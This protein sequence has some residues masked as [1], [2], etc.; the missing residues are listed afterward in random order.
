MNHNIY[1]GPAPGPVGSACI[2]YCEPD[3]PLL[4]VPTSTCPSHHPPSPGQLPQPLDWLSWSLLDRLWSIFP[5]QSLRNLQNY[6][7][8]HDTHLHIFPFPSSSFLSFLSGIEKLDEQHPIVIFSFSSF[9]E[10]GTK[11]SGAP[12]LHVFSSDVLLP[13]KF[14]TEKL[15]VP[16]TPCLMNPN[17]DGKN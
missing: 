7:S 17:T 3:H 6:L 15:Q 4:A 8:E 2:T 1:S 11:K 14:G 9:D 16:N 5:L 12:N 13:S 10:N